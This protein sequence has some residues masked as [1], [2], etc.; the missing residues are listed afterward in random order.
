MDGLSPRQAKQSIRDPIRVDLTSTGLQMS[1][2]YKWPYHA[3]CRT[4]TNSVFNRCKATSFCLTSSESISMKIHKILRT[5]TRLCWLS[6]PLAS[7]HAS[8]K[9]CSFLA[10]KLFYCLLKNNI[11]G[12]I[13][14]S[15]PQSVAH[16]ARASY[17]DGALAV[18]WG[19]LARILICPLTTL[20]ILQQ[21]GESRAELGRGLFQGINI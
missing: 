3:I 1:S 18:C 19:A 14:D 10:L 6:W 21:N 9:K 5:P 20:L 16:S 11:G 15:G 8:R 7:L 2:R 13:F 17:A 12:L 4:W